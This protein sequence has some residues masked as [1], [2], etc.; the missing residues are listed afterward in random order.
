[1]GHTA[2]R[3]PAAVHRDHAVPHRGEA[4]NHP[5]IFAAYAGSDSWKAVHVGQFVAMAMIIAGLLVLH[6]GLDLRA[7]GAAWAARLGAVFAVVALV[8]ADH[9]EWEARGAPQPAKIWISAGRCL[10]ERSYQDYALG[11]A[12]LLFAAAVVPALH[13]VG[14]A[15]E[16][17]QRS[18]R[19][20]RAPRRCAG[21]S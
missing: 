21:W 9:K 14:E 10:V 18:Q 1:M 16:R 3:G 19:A 13:Q 4:N 8:N 11:L 2:A 17:H 6:F 5:A 20:S 15:G 12:L 7:G